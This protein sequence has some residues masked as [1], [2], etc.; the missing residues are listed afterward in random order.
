MFDQLVHQL[1][2]HEN[3]L[4]PTMSTTRFIDGLRDEIKSVVVIQHPPDLDIACSLALLQEDVLLLCCI[5][6][7]AMEERWSMV[8]S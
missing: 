2:A 7:G 3:Q 8:Q 5:W 1:L 4:T 6:E